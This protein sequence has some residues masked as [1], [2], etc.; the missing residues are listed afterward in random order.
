[1]KSIWK[2]PLRVRDDQTLMVPAG[3]KPLSAQMEHG[4]LQLWVLVEKDNEL[5][6]MQ[7]QVR[8]TG[9]ACDGVGEFVDTFQLKQLAHHVFVSEGPS[10]EE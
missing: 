1:M 3:A 9:H 6:P 2:Y 7:V 5:S 4:R 8:G 10:N